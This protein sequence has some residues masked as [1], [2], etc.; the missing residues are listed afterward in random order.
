VRLAVRGPSG[1]AQALRAQRQAE[2]ADAWKFQ[3]RA[4]DV[5]DK[6]TAEK[7]QLKAF[8]PADGQ[9]EIAAQ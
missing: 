3:C 6:D 7:V 8:D 2:P 5:Q 4:A 9:A 1:C